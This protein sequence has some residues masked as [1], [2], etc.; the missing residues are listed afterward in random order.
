[1]ASGVAF[2]LVRSRF[3]KVCMTEISQPQA[4]R[5]EVSFCEAVYE[6]EKDVEGLTA[7]LIESYSQI[8]AVWGLGVLSLAA[9]LSH[10]AGLLDAPLD[11]QQE[12]PETLIHGLDLVAMGKL[13]E[14]LRHLETAMRL[15]EYGLARD[16]PQDV[17]WETVQRL[18]FVHK[19]HGDWMAAVA[20][21]HQAAQRD[22]V[23][24]HVELAKFYEHRAR[25][26]RQAARWTEAAITLVQ[27]PDFA[28]HARRRWL[29]DLEHRLARLQ[30]KL[31]HA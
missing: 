6:G 25:D 26:Y 11:D 19:R 18:S 10:V 12:L 15:Y 20:L 22:H 3:R 28:K 24:A 21:W 14:D 23:Y 2:R 16:L 30:R 5:R 4:V 1:M 13:F 8:Q 17:Y 31:D 29:A 27:A 9:L 7:R